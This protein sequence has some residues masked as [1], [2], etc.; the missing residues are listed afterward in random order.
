[1][2]SG[3]LCLGFFLKCLKDHF[4]GVDYLVAS[5]YEQLDDSDTGEHLG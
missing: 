2:F 4:L 5:L 1:M 3:F